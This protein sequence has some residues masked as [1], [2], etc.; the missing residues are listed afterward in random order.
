MVSYPTKG[1][2]SPSNHRPYSAV[3]MCSRQA[4]SSAGGTRDGRPPS[5]TS[6]RDRTTACGWTQCRGEQHT[7][8]EPVEHVVAVRHDP[9]DRVVQADEAAGI[10]FCAA[11]YAMRVVQNISRAEAE[12]TS[13]TLPVSANRLSSRQ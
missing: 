12:P 2:F 3:N 10:I 1:H 4:A 8:A 7:P 13:R 6:R 5:S 11:D 9:A